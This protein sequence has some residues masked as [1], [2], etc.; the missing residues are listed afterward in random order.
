MILTVNPAVAF[1]GFSPV[2]EVKIY[3][4]K[5]HSQGRTQ[6]SSD[7]D[8]YL[9]SIMNRTLTIRTPDPADNGEYQCEAHL[10]GTGDTVRASANL[11]VYG[12]S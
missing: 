4:Y 9:L 12:M 11:T 10:S 7:Q 8:K 3:W 2:S 6:L 5:V 1:S